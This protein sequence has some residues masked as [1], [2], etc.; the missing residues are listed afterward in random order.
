MISLKALA[1]DPWDSLGLAVGDVVT[2]PVT[3][4]VPFGVFVRVGEA[5]EG[6][7]TSPTWAGGPS[8]RGRS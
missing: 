3:K 4:V 1:E 8:P 6:W 7:S 2:G 5:A